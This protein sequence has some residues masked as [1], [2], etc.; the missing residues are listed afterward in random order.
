MRKLVT[1]LLCTVCCLHSTVAAKTIHKEKSLYRNIVVRESNNRR[2]LVFSV[3]RGDKNQTCTDLRD[4]KLLVFAYVRMVFAGLLVNPNPRRILVIGLGGGSIPTTLAELFPDANIDIVEIDRS[5]VR[6]AEKYFSFE[7][8]DNMKVIVSDARVYIRRANERGQ[9]YD[10]IIL[11]AFTGDYIPEHLMTVEFFEEV[12]QLMTSD[13]ALIANTFSNSRLYH[14][15]SVTYQRAF[16][17][18][19]NFKMSFTGNR[20]II[21]TTQ[22]LPDLKLLQARAAQ[23]AFRLGRYGIKFKTYPEH[24]SKGIDWDTSKRPLTDQFSPANLLR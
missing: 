19:F 24:M 2:C 22:Q 16:K 6:V 11:D 7:E 10:M 21:A 14:H 15:E 5:V 9:H 3:R 18:F 12:K 13:G 1:I 23:F 20:V 8:N 17:T 4:P